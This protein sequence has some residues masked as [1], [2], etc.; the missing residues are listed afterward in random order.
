LMVERERELS[1][2]DLAGR[3]EETEREEER[4]DAS[5]RAVDARSGEVDSETPLL[6]SDESDDFRRRWED[7]QTSF[8][9]EPRRS[10]EQADSLVAEALRRV[11]E[12]FSSERDALEGQW[13]RGEDV[14]TE[15]LRVILQRYRSFFNRLLSA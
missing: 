11:A 3:S 10:V 6:P 7:V 8:V 13:G 14:S 5:D 12:T 15:D 2:S 1:T 4:S 9:D